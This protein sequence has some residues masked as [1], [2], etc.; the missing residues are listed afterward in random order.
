MNIDLEGAPASGEPGI[1]SSLPLDAPPLPPDVPLMP[2]RIVKRIGNSN[3]PRKPH[4]GLGW[5]PMSA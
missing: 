4:W 1:Q 3:G 2:V 5:Q